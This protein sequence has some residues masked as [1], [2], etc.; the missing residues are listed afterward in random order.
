MRANGL[1]ID[2]GP[3]PNRYMTEKANNIV[4]SR[5][6]LVDP[7]LHLGPATHI[8]RLEEN[9]NPASTQCG[10]DWQD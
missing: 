8:S 6:V 7:S 5:F 4:L 10:E 9:K 1:A 3:T 2:S